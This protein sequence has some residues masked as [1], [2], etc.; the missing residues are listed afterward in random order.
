[1]SVFASFWPVW[2]NIYS[3]QHLKDDKIP[4]E[5]KDMTEEE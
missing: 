4:K 3:E 5:V 1:M 2:K